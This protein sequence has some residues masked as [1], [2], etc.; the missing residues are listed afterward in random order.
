[1]SDQHFLQR[2]SEV[3]ATR[4]PV[5]IIE[6]ASETFDGPV[7]LATSLSAEDQVLLH[8]VA[9][10][11]FP[12][13]IFMLDTG[14]HFEETYAL[15]DQTRLQ[16]DIAIETYFPRHQELEQA[17]NRHGHNFF[18]RSVEGRKRCCFIR[19]VEP[20]RRAL[21][22]KSAWITG[23]RREQSPTRDDIG[24]VTWDEANGLYKI[25]P[26]WRWTE[27]QVWDF[28]KTYEIPYNPLHDHGFPSI[29]CAPCTRAVNPGEDP[30]SGRWWWETPEQKE[31]GIHVVDGKVMPA[32]Q[33]LATLKV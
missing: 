25:N 23:L 14:R 7:T 31:C 13:S 12:I 33:P 8:L 19:K 27:D 4:E 26:L 18:R 10:N 11:R 6:W 21:E 16:Y 15:L 5:E 22:G 20:L 30:R 2:A 17:V 32:R 9:V 28:I 29:G 24:P 1:M 3:L